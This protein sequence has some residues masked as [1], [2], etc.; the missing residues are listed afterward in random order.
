MTA[1]ARQIVKRR[2]ELVHAR[3]LTS[4]QPSY[5]LARRNK[6]APNRG[7]WETHLN[8][9]QVSYRHPYQSPLP[10]IPNSFIHLQT[11]HHSPSLV[12]PLPATLRPS[13]TWTPPTPP[14]PPPP[15]PKTQAP[16]LSPEQKAQGQLANH[17]IRVTLQVCLPPNFTIEKER[18]LQG[19]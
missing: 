18:G 17:T 15:L 9:R 16:N 14:Q 12:P 7:L 10:P 13:P 8:N 6:S 4:N 3:D 19:K 2:S 11:P 5:L 1:G